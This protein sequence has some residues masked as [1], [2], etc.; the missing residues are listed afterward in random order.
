MQQSNMAA[1]L[2]HEGTNFKAYEYFGAHRSCNGSAVFRVWAP[3]ALTVSVVGDFNGWNE[4]SGVMTKVDDA[5]IYEVS[6]KD[7]QVYDEYKYLITAADG[8]K[9]YKSD[10]YGF[11]FATRPETNTKFFDIGGYDWGDSEWMK[12]RPSSLTASPV[13]IY[14]VH[15]GSWRTYDDGNPFN[16]RVAADALADYAK[17]MGYTHVELM[18]ITEF[19]FDGSWGYQV[20]GYYAPTSRYGTPYD[21]MYFVDRMHQSGIG[22]ILDW[23]PSHFPKDMSGLYRFDGEPCY[24]DPNPKRGEHKEWGTVVFDYQRPEV[25]CFLVSS[26]EFWMDMYHVDGIRVDAVASMLYLDYNRRDGEWEP[27][28]YGGK[29]NLEAVAFLKT[30]NEKVLSDHPGSFMIAEESTAWPLVTKPPEVGGLGFN[31][32]WNMGWMNDSL[33][34][35]S[36]DPFFRKDNQKKLTFAM[37]YA[38]SENYILPIS[39]DEV[40]H[41]KCSMINKMPGEYDQK[42]SGLMAFMGY[43]YAHPGKKLLFMGTE[44]AQFIEWDYKKQLDWFL[45]DYPAH[46]RFHDY[47]RELN[48][49][50]RDTPAFWQIEDSWDGFKWISLDDSS[51]NILAFARYD[52]AGNGVLAVFNFSPV[53]RSDYRMGL[54]EEGTYRI[55]LDSTDYEENPASNGPRFYRTQ[56]KPFHGFNCSAV[57]TIPANSARYFS[58]PKRKAVKKSTRSRTSKKRSAK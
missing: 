56:K 43:M 25:K 42:F 53:T 39:H 19:P 9:I 20:T 52:R 45:L 24:E 22:V 48:R 30:L 44:F 7:V 5:G 28:I 57:M 26:A 47:M 12:G 1:Y 31:F 35:F 58:I 37:M 15:L 10:P 8:S 23:V 17:D 41:G 54:P 27:N 11:H 18:P 13:N 36:M 34:Y 21:F 29:E 46:N 33:Q 4:E 32:K 14:E 51:Q 6:I 50:Y 40:V 2:F 49:F 16:Y 38:F 3:H 55:L